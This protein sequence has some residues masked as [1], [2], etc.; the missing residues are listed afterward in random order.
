MTD[1]LL[2]TRHTIPDEIAEAIAAHAL[3]ALSP[4]EEATLLAY[5][6]RHPEAHALL[7]EYR[8]VVDLL[9]FTAVPSEPP[10]ALKEGV[11][12]SI[13]DNQPRRR[14]L[15][16][17]SFR[18]RFVPVIAACLLLALLI[19]NLG[20]QLRVGDSP[21]ATTSA[22]VVDNT[23]DALK[24]FLSTPGLVSYDMRPESAAPNAWGRIYLTQDRSKAG[25][26]VSKLPP[27]PPDK[28]YQLWFRLDDQ[29]RV[30]IT[31]FSVDPTGAAVMVLSV[32]PSAH[33]YIS[34]GITQEPKGGSRTPTG[35]RVLASQEWPDPEYT[36][37]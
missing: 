10:P 28:T 8:A 33:K 1:H 2:D 21:S 3:E 24:V 27:L 9:P 7:D 37:P 5:L 31:T 13:R 18:L 34:C 26:A 17:P 15:A 19:W 11:L 36:Y 6:E 14:R 22:T 29:T 35:P 30:G 4:E 23:G 12:R 16:F 20:L 25:F 32:P